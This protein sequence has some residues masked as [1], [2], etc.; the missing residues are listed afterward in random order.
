MIVDADGYIVTNAHVVENATRIEVELPFETTGGAPGRS[1]LKRRGRVG[2]G[3]GCRDRSRDGPRRRQ[4]RGAR[5]AGAR[6]SATPT[7]FAPA[8]WCWRSAARSASTRRSPWASSAPWRASSRPEDPMI[9]IQTDATINPGQQRRRAGGHRR[10]SGRHQHAD[11]LAV[12][13]QRRDRL[14]RAEQH[15]PQRLQPDRKT[16]RVRRGEI[17]VTRRRS[18][19]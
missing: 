16:G 9:Y 14:R 3:A 5:A 19:R 13:R 2:R 18:R 15:R 10:A 6:R 4:S 12:G 17:G 11:P 7:R 1:I 8:S